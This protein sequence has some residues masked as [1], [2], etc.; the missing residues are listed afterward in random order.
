VGIGEGPHS[1]RI[2]LIEGNFELVFGG[3]DSINVADECVPFLALRFQF[4]PQRPQAAP[5]MGTLSAGPT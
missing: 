5:T 4:Q 2:A 1:R 3:N